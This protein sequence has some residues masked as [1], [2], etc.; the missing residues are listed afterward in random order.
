MGINNEWLRNKRSITTKPSRSGGL[1]QEI[2]R[3]ESMATLIRT[4]RNGTKYYEG[5][6]PCDR[7]DGKGIYYIGVCNGNL[8]P[9]YVDQGVCFKC[10]GRGKVAG[11]WKEYTPEYEAKLKARREAKWAKIEAERAEERRI[12][13]EKKEAER[14]AEEKRIAELKAI[15]QHVGTIGERIEFDAVIDHSAWFEYPSFRGFGM[16][17]MYIHSFKDDKGN[18]LVWKTAN[19]LGIEKG[20]RVHIKGTIKEHNVYRD[21]K[22][23]VLTRCKVVEIKG[24]KHDNNNH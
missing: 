20:E 3:K 4:D 17:T 10:H 2:E 7:C 5:L 21:E 13:E 22:Q 12:A 19:G 6:I 23:T 24:G 18:V 8:V 11:K 15:S 1:R 14:L 9:S 16:D